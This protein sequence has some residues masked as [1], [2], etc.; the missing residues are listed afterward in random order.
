MKKL[1]LA[2]TACAIALPAF[3]AEKVTEVTFDK[4]QMKCGDRHIDDGMKVTDLKS[5]KNFQNKDK[6]VI[7]HDDN[8]GKMVECNVD[9]K[10]KD[11]TVATCVT[12]G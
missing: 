3:A 7:F 10:T 5:C 11:L 12:K 6:T 1:L 4:T 2:I 9:K 8:S